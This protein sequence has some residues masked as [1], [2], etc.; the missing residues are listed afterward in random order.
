MSAELTLRELACP[1]HL[2]VTEAERKAAQTVLFSARLRFTEAPPA[3]V[4]D[5]LEHTICYADLAAEIERI[6]QAKPY[7]LVEHLGAEVFRGLQAAV[8]GRARLRL[9][10][11]KVNPPIANLRDGIEYVLES[12]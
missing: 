6:A 8:D 4:T 11:K 2:G 7:A 12:D 1:V 10:V 5:R 9:V 3:A